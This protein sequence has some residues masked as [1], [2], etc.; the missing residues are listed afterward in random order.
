MGIN[1]NAPLTFR[2]KLTLALTLTPERTSSE[3]VSPAHFV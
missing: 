3:P 1:G 2:K